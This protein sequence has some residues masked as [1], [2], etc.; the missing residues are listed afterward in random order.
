MIVKTKEA[1]EKNIIGQE[2]DAISIA[3]NSLTIDKELNGLDIKNVDFENELNNYGNNIQVS[4]EDDDENKNFIVNFKN[5]Q[6]EY[7]VDR[8]GNILL[9]G[10]NSIDDTPIVIS[11]I[12]SWTTDA[13]TDFHQQSIKNII[14]E[15][16]FV[17][18]GNKTAPTE[19]NDACSPF[20]A[21]IPDEHML[22]S[23]FFSSTTF[24]AKP[25]AIALLH[26]LPVHTNIIFIF[27]TS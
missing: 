15:V 27:I 5:T 11:S 2:K 7:I 3:W 14:T 23:R 26:V 13:N 1:R 24:L 9:K 25:S 8:S 17:D 10:T 19:L 4:Y 16:E 20:I 18:L 21:K 6:H 12:K 22:I